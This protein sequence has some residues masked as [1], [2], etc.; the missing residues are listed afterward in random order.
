MLKQIHIF[1]VQFNNIAVLR[2]ITL[3]NLVIISMKM[4]ALCSS[5]TLVAIYQTTRHHVAQNLKANKW[6]CMASEG[7]I[8]YLG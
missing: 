1:Y 7:A 8:N 2:D 5:E 4:E 6:V 3:C